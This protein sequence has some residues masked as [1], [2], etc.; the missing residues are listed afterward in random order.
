MGRRVST[1]MRR[2]STRIALTALVAA[3]LQLVPLAEAA[4]ASGAVGVSGVITDGTGAPASGAQVILSLN[5]LNATTGTSSDGSYEL[6]VPPGAY[7]FEVA[8][9]PRVCTPIDGGGTSCNS[10]G[11]SWDGATALNLQGD[12]TE[13]VTLPTIATVDT[14][15]VDEASAPVAN[16]GVSA[17]SSS[18][19][20]MTLSDGTAIPFHLNPQGCQTDSNGA[21][22]F[23]LPLGASADVN[24]YVSGYLPFHTAVIA[25]TDPTDFPVT[26]VPQTGVTLSGRVVDASGDPVTNFGVSLATS[27]TDVAYSSV[28]SD[29][30]YALHV[31]PGSYAMTLSGLDGSVYLDRGSVQ[32][33]IEQDRVLN[34]TLPALATVNVSVTDANNQ[35]VQSTVSTSLDSYAMTLEDG[36]RVPFVSV[37]L[38]CTSP[39][40][41][42]Y[43]AGP[44]GQTDAQGHLS[45]TVLQ[46][47]TGS[48]TTRPGN[49][50]DYLSM[51]TGFAAISD[52]T[53]VTVSESQYYSVSGLIR[54]A[55]G[56]PVPYGQVSLGN[57]TGY[58]VSTPN[59]DGSYSLYV[60]QGL[61]SFYV[62]AGGIS[63]QVDAFAVTADRSEDVTLPSTATVEIS[64]V[65][66]DGSPVRGASVNQTA[67]TDPSVQATLGDGTPITFH[68]PVSGCFTDANGSCSFP[69]LPGA[70]I[71]VRISPNGTLPV[72]TSVAVVSDPTILNIGLAFDNGASLIS[73]G[74]ASGAVTITSPP[75]TQIFDAT[76]Y[77]VAQSQVPLGATILTGGLSYQVTGAS[78]G[79]AVDVALRL[80][81]GSNPTNVYKLVGQQLVDVSTI[82][83][84]TGDTI[85][86]HLTDGGL[87]D[88]DGVANGTIVDPV[89]PVRQPPNAPTAVNIAGGNNQATV[90]WKSSGVVSHFDVRCA[91]T[92]GGPTQTVVATQSPVVVHGLWASK[93]YRCTVSA[94]NGAGSS[95]VATSNA[96]IP[97][98]LTVVTSALPNAQHGAAY[99]TNLLAIGGTAPYTWKK[100]APL[101][102][103]LRLQPGAGVI[104]GK[105]K[106]PGVYSISLQVTDHTK[107]T[108][109]IT[110]KTLTLTVT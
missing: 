105:P 16:A 103:G 95:G 54:D 49:R 64:V 96:F 18:P 61:Y 47:M 109:N 12:R 104:L 77:S 27:A 101:P 75:G 36:A 56:N 90:S 110:T 100:L 88:S 5:G 62:T 3:G 31:P 22:S 24:I 4:H 58:A 89:I 71:S 79:A 97:T 93:T 73:A 92:N 34:I 78:P 106:T 108:K 21:C 32:E 50:S 107:K 70:T 87:G 83:T 98:G 10:G 67:S 15:V 81:P 46:G 13:D 14:T 19:I 84:I 28:D 33:A 7:S 9:S 85:V 63:G 29:G 82:A 69:T 40:G 91:S 72:S 39:D 57:A 55:S 23:Q 66:S 30:S 37:Y 99:S 44:Q 68:N 45:L 80:P 11:I 25:S 38:A 42:T 26:L 41:S 74:S 6:Q 43:C 102:K 17:P 20:T 1:A 86:L 52:P 65:D 2:G 8:Y 48:F 60:P 59:T 76:A 53:N 94:T 51:L 35:G